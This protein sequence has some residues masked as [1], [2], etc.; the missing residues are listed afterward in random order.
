MGLAADA[1]KRLQTALLPPGRLWKLVGE[2]ILLKLFEGAAAEIV[3]LHARADDLRSESVPSNADE[4]LPE[5]EED[6]DLE[7]DGT[8]AERVARVVARYIARQKFRPIDIQ[9]TLAPLLGQFPEDVVVIETS[10]ATAV[11]MGDDREIYRFFVYRDPGL[12]GDYYLDSAQTLL[13]SFSH[14][15]TKGHVIESVDFLCDDPHSL[16]DRDILG[17]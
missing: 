3:R 14:S 7:P 13:D 15:H 11:L 2:S 17:A 10:R 1:Y 9:N 16:C 4:L 5:Y 12:P 8:D 6:L